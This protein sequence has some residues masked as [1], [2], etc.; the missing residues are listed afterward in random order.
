MLGPKRGH[1]LMNLLFLISQ[2]ILQLSFKQLLVSSL[3]MPY[4]L[5]QFGETRKAVM[6]SCQSLTSRQT[7]LVS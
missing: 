6:L 4:Q 7:L 2:S 1:H 5:N 3:I